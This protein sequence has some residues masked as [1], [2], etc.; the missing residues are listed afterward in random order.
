MT[1]G[2]G[3]AATPASI[4][5]DLERRIGAGGFVAGE[6]LPSELALAREYSTTRP[7]VRTALAS[8]ARRGLVAP[9]PGK[10]WLVRAGQ[11]AQTVGE[12]LTFSQWAAANGFE[13]GGRIVH[14]ERGRATAGEARAL[15]IRLGEE[16]V[17]FVR[18]RV[19]DGRPVMIERSTWAHP[20]AAVIE[21]LPHDVPSVYAALA[22]AGVSPELGDHR[23][24]AVAASSS[25]AELLHVRRSSPLL[26]VTVTS[27]TT[28]GRPIEL[29]VDRYVADFVTF[30]VRAQD[31]VRSLLPPLP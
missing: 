16:V 30:N 12:M 14:R 27:V 8:L 15:A 9:R 22:E 4:A 29:G 5:L 7:R 10:G 28:G 25:D 11:H 6:L 3:Q 13:Y 21:S 24:A 20:A 18:V 1:A 23:I 2:D 31:M 26:Q 17:R 19:I